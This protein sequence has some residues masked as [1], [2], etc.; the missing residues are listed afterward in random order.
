MK[1][2]LLS[3]NFLS[4]TVISPNPI[5]ADV[6]SNILPLM[7]LEEALEFVESKKNVEAIF[8]ISDDEQVMSSG[9]KEY[10]NK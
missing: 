6:I 5:E 2:R 1:P 10:L 7:K 8:Y 4:V 3:D 9:F